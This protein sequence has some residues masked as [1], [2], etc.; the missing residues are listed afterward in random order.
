MRAAIRFLLCAGLLLAI[1]PF[2]ISSLFLDQRGVL[3]PG[4]VQSKDERVVVHYSSWSL[5]RDVTVE[6]EPPQEMVVA[7]LTSKV[8]ADYFD[9]LKKGDAVK[10]RY[11]RREDVPHVPG[12]SVLREMHLL[13]TV[14]L[15]DQ[16]AW[17]GLQ[18]AFTPGSL[19]LLKA[20]VIAVFV[21]VLWRLMHLPL[22]GWAVG[23]CVVAAVVVSL[24]H[25]FPTSL[26]APQNEVRSASGTVKS[27]ERVEWLLRA[28]HQRGFKADQP[29]EIVGV[30]FIPDGRTEPVVAV[31][32]IDAGSVRA[33][34]E[35]AAV[36]IDYER[37]TPRT[38]RIRGATRQFV[39]RN[40]RGIAVELVASL[41]VILIL[42]F[43]ASLLGKGYRHL[44]QRA[45]E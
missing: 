13:P 35:G 10:L 17:T 34:Q 18:L 15:A 9:Q 43:S 38:A 42:L 3:I 27:L 1:A 28:D 8:D 4:H 16:R 20:I 39:R 44:T 23:V 32:L 30:R 40:L 26:P 31:D 2:V 21:L 22:F 24:V 29:I 37:V 33:L 5:S 6:Y 14:R 36:E 41:A 11:L 7:F 45:R 19:V 12:A 25:D